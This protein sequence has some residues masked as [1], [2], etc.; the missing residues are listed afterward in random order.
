MMMGDGW[1]EETH[2]PPEELP[3]EYGENVQS[4]DNGF[5][6]SLNHTEQKRLEGRERE[7]F[8]DLA[9]VFCQYLMPL[10]A[11]RFPFNG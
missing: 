10:K 2:E 7:F 11:Y 5:W 4:F 3:Q 6:V 1:C 8:R 9:R